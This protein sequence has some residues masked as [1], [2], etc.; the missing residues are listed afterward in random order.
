MGNPKGDSWL[1]TAIE[2]ELQRHEQTSG[3]QLRVRTEDAIAEIKSSLDAHTKKLRP[4]GL[5][6]LIVDA[7]DRIYGTAALLNRRT[8]TKLA[9]QPAS[10]KPPTTP[11]GGTSCPEEY[12]GI[13]S[14]TRAK[15]GP[16]RDL[17]TARRVAKIVR[18]VSGESHWVSMLVQICASLDAEQIPCPKTWHKRKPRIIDW[19][20]AAATEPGLAKKAIAHHLKNSRK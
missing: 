4:K 2:A 11:R 18:R 3:S 14:H 17:A 19:T 12:P 13:D 6:E 20:D 5:L 1:D 7:V 10:S 16:K 9:E 8:T 15:P